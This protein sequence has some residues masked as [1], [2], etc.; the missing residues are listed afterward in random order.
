MPSTSLE[1]STFE[2]VCNLVRERS[3]IVLEKGKEYLVEARLQ[4]LLRQ[5]KLGSLL[6]LEHKLRSQPFD[7]LHH[8]VVDA[9]TTNETLFFRDSRPFEAL[10]LHILPQLLERNKVSRT[11]NIWCGASSSGQEPYSIAILLSEFL[12]AHPGWT[13]RIQASDISATMLE[14]AG[15]GAYNQLE[16]NRGLP[17]TLLVK[18]FERQGLEWRV[19][20]EIRSMV[21]FF[22]MN[23]VTTWPALPPMDIIFLRNV[24]IYFDTQTK[25]AILNKMRLLLKPQGFLFLGG[26]ETTL[27]LDSDFDQVYFDKAACYRPKVAAEKSNAKVT[28]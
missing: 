7:A 21:E 8:K 26:A 10:R 16:I 6:E 3:G 18:Y 11:I 4:P 20:S 15:K 1:A 28:A 22:R 23:L 12:A 2:F 5:E 17:A 14:R 19:K 27:Y 24:L 25:K 9:M 13:A